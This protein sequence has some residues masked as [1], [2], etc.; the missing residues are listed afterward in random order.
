MEVISGP[1]F[2]PSHF[3]EEDEGVPAAVAISASARAAGLPSV[4]N[5][6]IRSRDDEVDR[7]AP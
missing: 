4:K 7:R 2:W 1:K 5:D 3:L 6:G